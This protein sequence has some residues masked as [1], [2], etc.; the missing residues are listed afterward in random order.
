MSKTFK[1]LAMRC[2]FS[3]VQFQHLNL[4]ANSDYKNS[5]EHFQQ[6]AIV[7]LIDFPKYKIKTTFYLKGQ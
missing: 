2:T 7:D 4:C 6:I 3:V 5:I 1:Y